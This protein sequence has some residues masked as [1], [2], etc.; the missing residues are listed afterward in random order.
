MRSRFK[1][2][3]K[4]YRGFILDGTP[5]I[6]AS[7]LMPLFYYNMVIDSKYTKTFKSN[8][9]TRQKYDELLS[10]AVVLRDHK[11]TVSK[12]V[13]ANLGQYLEYSKLDFL[14]EMRARYKD[15]IPSSFDVQLYTQVFNFYQNKFDAIRKHLDFRVVGFVGFEFYKRDTKKNKKGDLKKVVTEKSKTPLSICLTYLAR[16]G[17][18]NT[19][20][21]IIKQLETCDDKKRDFYNN[22]IRCCDKFGFER[23]LGLALRK[24]NRVIKQ[25]SE[26]PIVFNSLTFGGRCRKTRIID[27][28]SK[29]GSVIN[30]FVSLSGI[31]RK[32]FDI[33]VHFN[34]DWHGSMKDYRKTNPDYEYVLTFNEKKHQ[35]NV[36]LCKD[37]QR[38]IPEAGDNIVGIDVNC[39]HNLFTLSDG[40]TYDYDRQLVNDF[41]KFSLEVDDLKKNKSYVVGKRKQQKLDTLK[42][43]MLK[44]EQQLIAGMC[45]ELAVQGVNHIVMEDLDNGFGRSFVKDADNSDINYNRKVKYLGLSSLKQEVERIARKYGIAVS[46]VQASYTSKMCPICGCID[47][48]N[49]PNQ[50]TFDCV[51]CGHKDNADI[52][53]AINIRNRVLVTVLR[54]QL[55]KQ[56]GNGAY[57]PRRLKREKVKEV[58]LSFRR[59]LLEKA[60]SEHTE[61]INLNTFD[62]V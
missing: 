13:N 41:C 9:L 52:N 42:M 8:G 12:Y 11:N 33:P 45:K 39:K 46:T 19:L 53:A 48:E 7:S 5:H 21:Y 43:K 58:L 28:N 26:H 2:T 60:E 56:L 10:F 6:T 29:F 51:E 55:L 44:S 31:G 16:Y 35:V 61:N 20:D 30:S 23:L 17:N 57:E 40:M 37:G 47:D 54:E 14:K 27:Y 34:K 24:R 1:I 3:I 50:E 15:V 4:I 62:Y 49:R 36:N 38:Y 25:Y 22:I 32:S 18:D 59:S